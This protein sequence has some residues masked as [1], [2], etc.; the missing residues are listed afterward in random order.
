MNPED[1]E[2]RSR[3]SGRR[4][5]KEYHEAVSAILSQYSVPVVMDNF[6][7][8]RGFVFPDAKKRTVG[9][10]P[11]ANLGGQLRGPKP[12]TD[13]CVLIEGRMVLG[14]LPWDKPTVIDDE[15]SV[16]ARAL[17]PMP[18]TWDFAVPCPHLVKFG[19][20]WDAESG[21]WTCF[22]CGVSIFD[23]QVGVGG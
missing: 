7:D 3:A 6:S 2:K 15:F 11:V 16:S 8:R 21:S 4:D 14:W 5:D 1:L 10:Y 17:M 12:Y 19:G 13:I 18:D 9:F 20:V 23:Q 22:G